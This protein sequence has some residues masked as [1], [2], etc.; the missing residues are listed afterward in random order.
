MKLI[1]YPETLV[2]NWTPFDQ[3]AS[4]RDDFNR[5][6][7]SGFAPLFREARMLG[8]W[9]PALDVHEENDALVVIAELPG[10]KKEEIDISL[11]KGLLTISGE[12]KEETPSDEGKFHRNERF[13]G[14]FSRTVSLPAEVDA[15]GVTA[16]YR[17]GLLT[18]R[19]PKS[20]EAKPKQITVGEN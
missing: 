19:L 17:D 11:H 9:A 15:N 16:S 7:E 18:V 5:L 4:I 1:R 12:R 3:L 10:M 8:G 6:F 13:Y 2:S 14:K 20:E